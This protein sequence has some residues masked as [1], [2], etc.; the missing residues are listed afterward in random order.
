MKLFRN[1]E[2]F[3]LIELLIVVAI[4]GVLAAV[5]IPMYNGYITEAK[6]KTTRHQ[7]KQIVT[8]IEASIVN[9]DLTGGLVPI[10]GRDP[11]LECA[12]DWGVWRNQ[13]ASHFANGLLWD[14]PWGTPNPWTAGSP[15]CC[16]PRDGD[17]WLKGIS[18]ITG[19]SNFI[20]VN[21]DVDGTVDNRLSTKIP[22]WPGS[23]ICN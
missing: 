3:T 1:Q 21:T 20:I 9:C 15:R 19:D 17:D 14:N 22:C 2:G 13:L 16:R 4:I 8:F 10:Q 7:H 23:R 18:N 5:G 11:H 12:K 6:V